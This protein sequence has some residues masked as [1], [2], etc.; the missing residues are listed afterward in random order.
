LGKEYISGSAGLLAVGAVLLVVGYAFNPLPQEGPI[1]SQTVA[2]SDLE[3]PFL[4][5]CMALLIAAVCLTLGVVALVSLM[6]PRDRLLRVLAGIVFAAGTIGMAGY[7]MVMV[8]IRALVLN[9][10]LSLD[11][12]G[13]A[14]DDPTVVAAVGF[15]LVGFLGG[16]ILAAWALWRGRQAPRWVPA[17]MLV[18][19][20]SQLAPIPGATFTVIQFLV[21]ATGLAGAA[22]AANDLAH[23]H[24][25]RSRRVPGIGFRSI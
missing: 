19:V 4:L 14:V 13:E 11:D 12:I 9:G 5:S 8:F 6:A 18:F 1:T 2:A 3:G 7:A 16:L 17:V 20:A 23:E 21:L 24:D 10:A 25:E 22:I 15:I